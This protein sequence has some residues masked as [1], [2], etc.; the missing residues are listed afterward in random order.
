MADLGSSRV[1]GV[2]RIAPLRAWSHQPLE[3]LAMRAR[4][5]HRNE[6]QC[7]FYECAQ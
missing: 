7:F 1:D 6:Q 5:P 3:G 2:I 4:N